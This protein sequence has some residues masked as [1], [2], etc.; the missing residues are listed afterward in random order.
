M[1]LIALDFSKAF[2]SVRHS[3][4]LHKMASPIYLVDFF[5]NRRH[6]TKFYGTMSGELDIT[7]SIMQGSA[8]GSASYVINAADL[9]TVTYIHRPQ[10]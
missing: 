10:A 1:R 2:H 6:C 5:S 4:L 9:T 3:N 7:A 8:I